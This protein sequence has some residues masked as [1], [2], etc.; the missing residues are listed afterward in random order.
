MNQNRL[1][2]IL[3][4]VL[5]I[6]GGVAF[7]IS[8]AGSALLG[9]SN[10]PG[11]AT[12]AP[13]S[14]RPLEDPASNSVLP[15]TNTEE[16]PLPLTGVPPR[17]KDDTD[18][19]SQPGETRVPGKDPAASDSGKTG[20]TKTGNSGSDSPPASPRP[21]PNRPM[22]ARER[23]EEA[24]KATGRP[25]LT[26]KLSR[27]PGGVSTSASLKKT[28]EQEKWAEQWYA[29]G[30]TPPEMTPTPVHGKIM[31]QESRE[32]LAKATVGLI[33]F[34]PLDGVAGG[35]L[36]PVITEFETDEQ[37]F[38]G[39]DI[40]ASKLAPQNYP[41]LAIGITWETHRI[42]AAMPIETLLVGKQN[43]LGIF[44][45]PETPYTLKADAQQFGGDLRVVATGELDPQRWHS[46]K[47][48]EAFSWFP[49]C[50]VG[51]VDPLKGLADVIGTWD[52]KD[53]P[54]VSLL[55]GDKL[56][57][58][59][60]PARATTASSTSTPGVL[61]SPFNT[62]LFEND[63]LTPISGQV[64][65]G[66]GAA[67]ANAVVTT[68]GDV[69][70]QS[71]VTDAAG[72][73]IFEDPPEKTGALVCVH[74]NYVKAM[75]APVVP[76]DSDV[77]I[78][79]P[80]PRPRIHMLVTDKLTQAPLTEISIKVTGLT[81]FGQSAGA[82]LPVE[83]IELTSANGHFV[84]EWEFAIQQ[85][86]LEK[87][88]YF[89]K[90][91]LD[92]ST[93]QQATG[94][95]VVELTPGRKLEITPKTYTAAETPERWFPDAD[96]GPGIYTAW[97]HHWIE[98]AVDFG[99]APEEGEEGGSFDVVLGCTNHGIVDNEYQFKVD[100]YVDGVKKGELTIMADSLNERTARMSLGKLSGSH[101]V[102][103]IWTND[104]WIPD[105]L[106]ANIRYGS[107]KFLEQ[108]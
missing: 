61:P 92:P 67:I 24:R 64:V 78:V 3:L 31:S 14:A 34:F 43:E 60:C 100:V 37:G 23:E 72:W 46:A 106:D 77:Q 15:A 89:P 54:Y 101:T 62:L 57:Q 35:P 88:G 16:E 26:E 90:T 29:E 82:P 45:A 75:A 42:V 91:I 28:P 17:E 10:E 59:R 95:I 48:A 94:E 8:D 27:T 98:W 53:A 85:I 49:G 81:P 12:N 80:V 39:G 13:V 66:E 87:L 103:L 40:P 51:K 1:L 56:L 2:L 70:T 73:F 47:R 93:A 6:G 84:L 55:S 69:V 21:D 4:A 11:D 32:G 7:A 71:A 65:N 41:P 33:S 22:T 99:D 96:P 68:V 97:S 104:K 30:F 44:W 50:T 105:Q 107:L 63:A 108:P 52:E 25:A 76:G 74:D 79:M 9:I 58:T 20:D 36:L 18:T 86:T 83:F 38:F 5:L 19:V 102:R